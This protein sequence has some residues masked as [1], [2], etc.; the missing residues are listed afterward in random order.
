MRPHE[1]KQILVAPHKHSVVIRGPVDLS[2][3]AQSPGSLRGQEK[4]VGQGFPG[5]R[6]FSKI[7]DPNVVP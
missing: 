6:G 5:A 7:G 2:L 1:Y 4:F 3:P